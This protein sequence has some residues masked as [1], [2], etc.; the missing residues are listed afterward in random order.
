MGVVREG[1]AV[2][3]VVGAE[4][5]D[6]EGVGLPGRDGVRVEV[7]DGL[8]LAEGVR[9]GPFVVV[10]VKE[11]ERLRLRVVLPLAVRDGESEAVGVAQRDGVGLGVAVRDAVPVT[12]AVGD[13]VGV[14]VGL[15]ETVPL[16]VPW[17]LPVGDAVGLGVAVALGSDRV[18]D[19]DGKEG[20]AEGVGEGLGGAEAER[21]DPVA[22]AEGDRLRAAER[23]RVS[24]MEGLAGL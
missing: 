14:G 13:G 4:E 10:G 6:G 2:A 7:S 15:R 5:S 22:D 12:A 8:R 16:P 1:D 18:G 20:V 9:E 24:V 19:R 21:E 11:T 23:V 17:R 3:E